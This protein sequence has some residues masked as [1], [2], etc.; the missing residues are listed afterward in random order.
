MLNRVYNVYGD[1][2]K[3]Y[4]FLDYK[5]PSEYT[6]IK[7]VEYGG[8]ARKLG[9]GAIIL[10]ALNVIFDYVVYG[11][12]TLVSNVE[13]GVVSTKDTIMVFIVSS[14]IGISQ[15]LEYSIKNVSYKYVPKD[16]KEKYANRNKLWW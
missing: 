10:I 3:R 9:I 16:V 1:D 8:L 2:G 7:V 11:K 5:N 4:E 13:T 12:I 14:M 6:T 15:M